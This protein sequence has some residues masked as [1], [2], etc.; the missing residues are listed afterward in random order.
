MVAPMFFFVIGLLGGLSRDS[1]SRKA[2]GVALVLTLGGIGLAWVCQ[3]KGVAAY[4]D[5]PTP[6]A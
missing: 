6:H 2:L 3:A 5:L 4:T 1:M